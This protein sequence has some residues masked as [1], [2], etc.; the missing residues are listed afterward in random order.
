MKCPEIQVFESAVDYWVRIGGDVYEMDN[1]PQ[2]N[3]IN[4]YHGSWV[5]NKQYIFEQVEK[6]FLQTLEEIPIGLV[7]NIISQIDK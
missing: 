2:S 1:N 7:K 4:I 5:E 6:N 3:G